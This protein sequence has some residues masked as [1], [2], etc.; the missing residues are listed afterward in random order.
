MLC[1]KIRE[2]KGKSLMVVGLY[3]QWKAPSKEKAND[4]EGIKRQCKRLEKVGELLNKVVNDGNE[5]VLAGDI[6]IDRHLPNNPCQ[7]PELKAL[8]PILEDMMAS[9]NLVQMNHKPTRHMIGQKSSLLDLILTSIPERILNVEN[10]LNTLLEHE[11]V[12]C[13]VKL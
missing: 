8:T 10:F 13:V 6:N 7:R 9:L 12:R 11:G 5:L 4:K 3:R 2:P 1:L